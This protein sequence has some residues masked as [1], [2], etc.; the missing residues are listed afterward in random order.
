[1]TEGNGS[2]A[3]PQRKPRQYILTTALE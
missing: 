2:H 1:M 3:T